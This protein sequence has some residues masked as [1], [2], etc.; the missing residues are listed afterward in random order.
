MMMIKK[1]G[2]RLT[3]SDDSLLPKVRGR[4]RRPVSP[5]VDGDLAMP[6]PAPAPA[7]ARER[8]SC[9]GEAMS[10]PAVIWCWRR[11]AARRAESS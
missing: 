1:L 11:R 4:G 9:V 2:G 6:V 3:E 5:A 10:V 7:P 8:R